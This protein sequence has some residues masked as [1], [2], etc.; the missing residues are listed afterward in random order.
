MRHAL[1]VTNN[2]VCVQ[3]AKYITA[4]V[5]HEWGSPDEWLLGRAWY[6]VN[7]AEQE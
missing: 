1:F 6:V 4:K 5:C 3:E 7:L 2:F